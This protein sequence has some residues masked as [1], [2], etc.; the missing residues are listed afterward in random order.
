MCCLD[1]AQ[2]ALRLVL[3]EFL[4]VFGTFE[5]ITTCGGSDIL[6]SSSSMC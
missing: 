4:D 1:C 5:A 3:S 2:R 6:V